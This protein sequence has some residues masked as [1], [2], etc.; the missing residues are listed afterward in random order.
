VH[1]LSWVFNHQPEYTTR[2]R[3][4]DQIGTYLSEFGAMRMSD[5]A[6]LHVGEW[7][8]RLKDQ[9]V[10]ASTIADLKTVLSAIFTTALNDQIT[11]MHPCRAV[12]TPTVARKS[13][14]I[15]TPE[16]FDLIHS[17][18]PE[19]RWQT[20]IELDVESGLRWG[21]L[22]EL[23]VRDLNVAS[24]MLTVARA[25]VEMNARFREADTARFVVKDYPKDKQYRR[26]KL[27]SD[28]TTVL[29]QH[30]QSNGLNRDDLLFAMPT[31]GADPNHTAAADTPP[32]DLT[33]LG[34]TDRIRSDAP[35]N[36]APSPPTTWAAAAANTAATPAPTTEPTAARSAKTTPAAA[37]LAARST[38]TGTSLAAGSP[39]TSGNP[40]SPPPDSTST[41]TSTSTTYATPTHPGSSP[42][43]PTS[44]PSKNA[45]ATAGSEPPR[46]T[47]TP[48]P[49]PTTPPST[50]STPSTEH[51]PE[52]DTAPINRG[53]TPIL[54]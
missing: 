46:N 45:S 44:K 37:D 3:Y 2:Q 48:S 7:I 43:E 34:R 52:P 25:V 50:P 4:S 5:I 27:S 18:L 16:Q 32:P 29:G 23:R 54:A 24:R 14:T 49:T 28:I 1:A 17:A 19:P 31:P 12:K 35:T 39:N 15:V 53:I 26:V 10:S 47:S 51:E 13:R 40:Q 22:T 33:D 11:A 38:P 20:L 8:G 36:T 41:S 30:N 6:P 21:E 42:A 9:N